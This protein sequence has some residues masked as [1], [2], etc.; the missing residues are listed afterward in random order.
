VAVLT[1]PSTEPETIEQYSIRV[2][3]K[4]KLGR[5]GIND[6]VLLVVAVKDD[7]IRIEVGYGLEGAIPDA[8]AK[9]IASDIIRPR[10]NQGDF[11]GGVTDGVNA[12]VQAIS[13]ENLPAP[14][15]GTT[16]PSQVPASS[17]HARAKSASSDDSDLWWTLALSV[18][19][20]VFFVL[21]SFLRF[22][23]YLRGRPS[24]M[25]RRGRGRDY[26][27][28]S[29]GSTFGDFGGGGS[30]GGGGGDSFSGGGGDFGGG[31]ASDGGGDGGGG[32]GG[33]D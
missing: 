25:G 16:Y 7:T 26:Y 4:W 20:P 33:G 8:L 29:S 18:G 17:S 6:G 5:K 32:D 1:V 14:D 30:S 2:A 22:I 24:A 19:I 27:D 21:I 11:G 31:G 28:S 15:G 10:F 23:S 9:R 3:E 13:G 12:L